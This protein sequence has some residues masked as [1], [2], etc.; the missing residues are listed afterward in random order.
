MF[1]STTL[2]SLVICSSPL[3]V[4]LNVPDECFPALVSLSVV[5][6]N[7]LLTLNADCAL[8]NT[9]TVA[10]C[11]QIS[12]IV[13]GT[14][15]QFVERVC[16]RACD[17]LL[18]IYWLG[19]PYVRT[20]SV[21]CNSSLESTAGFEELTELQELVLRDN[22]R[23]RSL[24]LAPWTCLTYLDVSHSALA[25]L[26][27]LAECR[28]L[29]TLDVRGCALL[30]ELPSDLGAAC[31]G[32]D[33]LL[34]DSSAVRSL[35]PLAH[36]P[37]LAVCSARE[38]VLM[39]DATALVTCKQLRAVRIY[40]T[41]SFALHPYSLCL[42]SLEWVDVPSSQVLGLV[43]VAELLASCPN[44]AD[45]SVRNN[46]CISFSRGLVH[47]VLESLDARECNHFPRGFLNLDTPKLRHL[48]LSRSAVRG[49]FSTNT[50]TALCSVEFDECPLLGSV[51]LVRPLLR[52]SARYCASLQS[53]RN[54]QT[55]CTTFSVFGSLFLG[56]E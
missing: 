1:R 22:L 7:N 12:T 55:Y 29:R 6:C 10:V 13:I 54:L 37:R 53:V 16:V 33:T 39:A 51:E 38:C 2:H 31:V 9:L 20:F 14:R 30:S 11:S 26:P 45:C 5:R 24:P 23:L 49:H 46:G 56:V 28:A 41:A 34:C 4:E 21:Q 32:L 40:R 8:L 17:T 19:Q 27:S 36:A 52:F 48:N 3:L 18:E 44:L 47:S 15:A 25:Q 42:H 35:A 43:E 50:L